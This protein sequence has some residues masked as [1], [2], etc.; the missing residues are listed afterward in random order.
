M[1]KMHIEVA[2]GTVIHLP[3]A[4]LPAGAPSEE[5]LARRK[6]AGAKLPILNVPLPI[7][8]GHEDT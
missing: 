3:V 8:E 6:A 1:E 4:E 7:E 5:Y 2:G